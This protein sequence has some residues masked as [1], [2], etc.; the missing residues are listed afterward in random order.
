MLEVQ[1][2][3]ALRLGP[4]AG[5]LVCF[6]RPGWRFSD[7][8]PVSNPLPG[9]HGHPATEP[10]P[11]LVTGGHPAVRRGVTLGDPRGRWTS[12]RPSARCSACAH[13]AAATTARPGPA[14]SPP[15]VPWCPPSA[16]D[17]AAAGSPE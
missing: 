1:L 15:A 14:P 16:E 2:P 11:F 17:G 9:N 4:E 7:T 3:A 12:R 5:D 13:P 10:I 6:T 8:T